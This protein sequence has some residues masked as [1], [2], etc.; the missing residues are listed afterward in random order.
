MSK[1]PIVMPQL[2]ES[3]T[4]ATIV[5]YCVSP[6]DRVEAEQEILEVE[7]NKAVMGVPTPCAGVLESFSAQIDQVYS[8]G[9]VLGYLEASAEEARKAGVSETPGSASERAPVTETTRSSLPEHTKSKRELPVPVQATGSGYFSPRLRAR[10]NDLGLSPTELGVVQG[11]GKGGRVTIQDFEAFLDSL[12]SAP[13]RKASGLR[14]AIADAMRRSWTRPLATVGVALPL[15]CILEHRKTLAPSPGPALYIA[16]ALAVAL[17]EQPQSAAKLVGEK[18]VLPQTFDI[19]VAVEVPDGVVVP[20][21]RAL[22][23]KPLATIAGEYREM[24]E[25]ARQRR[26]AAA[27]Q[28]GAIASVTNFGPLGIT[29]ATPIPDPDETIIAGLGRGE[30]RPVWNGSSFVP[31]LQGELT[32]SFDHRIVD[33]GAAGRLLRSLMKLLAKPEALAK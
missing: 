20:V 13:T 17:A 2:G 22:D 25:A 27:D 32:L 7:T 11:S 3:I 18:L 4:E 5:R 21:L 9:T 8:I 14:L 19:G 31:E 1:I 26:L 24:L 29:W 33:G 30:M 16:K 15:A 6:G 28:G 23:Q 12:A 10:M